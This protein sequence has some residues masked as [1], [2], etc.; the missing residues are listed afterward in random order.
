M[1]HN[2]LVFHNFGD[3]I[4]EGE[5]PAWWESVKQLKVNPYSVRLSDVYTAW[6]FMYY[7]KIHD[8]QTV[9]FQ[10]KLIK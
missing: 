9:F 6:N 7:N 8:K 5:T 1:P 2:P 4:S 3:E 10:K